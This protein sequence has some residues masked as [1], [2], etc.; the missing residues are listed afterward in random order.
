VKKPRV[1]PAT[2]QELAETPLG[3][4]MDITHF[5]SR[6][7]L[8]NEKVCEGS[9][10]HIAV[11][12]IQDLTGA[13]EPYVKAHCHPTCDEIGLVLGQPGALEYEM[14]LDGDVHQVISPAAIFIPAGTTHRARALRG[15]GAYMCM[16][17]D[18][19]GPNPSNIET[20]HAR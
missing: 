16:L 4:P 7:V 5:L 14:M 8:L 2:P 3:R 1:I 12:L 13:P 17:M 10:A 9:P 15:N 6:F 11:H 20:D 18:P 19:K